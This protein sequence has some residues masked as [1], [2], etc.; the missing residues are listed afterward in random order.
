MPDI[1]SRVSTV[2]LHIEYLTKN[3]QALTEVT[4]GQEKLAIQLAETTRHLSE[5]INESKQVEKVLDSVCASNVAL[6][7]RIATLEDDVD[8]VANKLRSAGKLKDKLLY[9]SAGMIGLGLV[10]LTP[11]G[12]RLKVIM[13][14]LF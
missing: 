2:E 5:G 9:G 13:A 6:A 7:T 12:D 11:A 10:M 3:V 8:A 4:A 14:L 1:H